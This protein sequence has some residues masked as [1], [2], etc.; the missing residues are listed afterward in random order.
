MNKPV[1]KIILDMSSRQRKRKRCV[2]CK[3]ELSHSAYIRHQNPIVCPERSVVATYPET[4]TA[5]GLNPVPTE[6][7]EA[8]SSILTEETCPVS[9]DSDSESDLD[10]AINEQVTSIFSDEFTEDEASEL[11]EDEELVEQS[12][13]LHEEGPRREE[14]K[15]VATHICL[16][17]SFFQLCYK[18]SERGISLLLSFLRAILLWMSSLMPSSDFLL[19]R[20]LLPR[21]VYFLQKLFRSDTHIKM[22][23]VCPKCHSLYS[24]KDSTFT[25]RNGTTESARCSY[26]Q[27]PD[28]PHL[29]RRVKCD[30]LLMKKVKH[31]SKYKLVP[32]KEY[33]YNSL[34]SSL[35]KLFGRR[36]FSQMCESW[37][38]RSKSPD[39]YTDIYDGIVWEK[40]QV[41]NDRPFL[42]VPN[43]LCLILNLDW[44]NPFKHIEYSVGVI[45]LVIANIPRS[46]RYK[47]ENVIIIRYHSWSKRT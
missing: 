42:K 18:I 27:F 12:A 8:T 15:L 28:H 26:I 31:G 13:E 37:R 6:D 43:N 39:V 19:L 40:F 11:N 10:E 4:A 44:F 45:Y 30:A 46:E 17:I 21:N 2:K 7:F 24:H 5:T 36:G 14:I 1:I 33:I 9:S 41:V 3:Q 47:L 22:Y 25:H 38:N 29:S 23:V 35:V 34:K 20:D 16:F 32:Y